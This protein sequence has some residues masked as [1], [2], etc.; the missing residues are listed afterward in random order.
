MTGIKLVDIAKVLGVSGARVT[1]LKA[2]GMPVNSVDAAAAWYRANVNQIFSP[3]LDA[4]TVPPAAADTM[5]AIIADTYD[6]NVARAKREHH[7]ANL[8]ELK[9]RQVLGELVDASR[10]RRVVTSWAAMARSALEKIPDKLS[11]RL[12]AETDP[13]SCHA[14][15]TAE[16]DLVLADLAA[17][18]R[19]I[20]LD[21]DDGRA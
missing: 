10:V 3:K 13:V 21:S 16:M 19:S 12:A 14:L 17:G 2:K 9:E 4:I 7:E 5:A 6:I 20:K 1:Q 8:A 11:D 18:A 15:M